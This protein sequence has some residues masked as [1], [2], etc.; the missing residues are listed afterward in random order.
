ME[1]SLIATNDE[2]RNLSEMAR[3]ADPQGRHRI[4]L[5]VRDVSQLFNSMDPSPFHEKDLDHD[6]EEFIISWAQEFHRK[7]PLELVVHLE[8]FPSGREPKRL[9]EDAVHNYFAYRTRLN[10]LEFRRLM[11]QG[12]TS[13]LVG[14]LF[15]SLCLLA[16]D[17]LSSYRPGTWLNVALQSLS[18]AGWVAM[19]RPLE[20]YL[21]EWWPLRRRGQIFEKLSHIPVAVQKRAEIET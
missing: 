19:A 10:R 15:L 5:N 20:I 9:I 3:Q 6:A 13:L 14:L 18:I 12:R 17:Y 4:E 16:S 2:L 7:E 8:K 11:K 21:Y 1:S